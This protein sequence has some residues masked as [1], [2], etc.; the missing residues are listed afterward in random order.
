MKWAAGARRAVIGAVLAASVLSVGSPALG[1]KGVRY[2]ND[3][4]LRFDQIQLV[5]THNSYHLRPQPPFDFDA[6][7]LYDH[8]PT[9][10]QLDRGMRSFEFDAYNAPTTPVFHTLVIDAESR[11]ATLAKCLAPVAKWSRRNP[12]H[13]PMVVIVEPKDLPVAANPTIQGVIDS[14]VAKQQ[15]APWDTDGLDRLDAIVRKAFGSLLVTPDEVRAQYPTLRDAIIDR[16]WPTLGKMRGRVLALLLTEGI[17]R[18]VY[19]IGAS[20]LERRAMFVPSTPDMP[21]AAI[22][23]MEVPDPAAIA[24]RVRQ[25]FLVRTQADAFG[26][27]ARA[28]DRTR[29]RNA[30][31]GGAQVISTDYPVADP[32]VST[33]AVDLPGSAIARCNPID[34]PAWCRARDVER[35]T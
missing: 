8:A 10:A 28:N 11:C 6:E 3:D 32:T 27:E 30:I 34:T 25:H 19:P 13:V 7:T 5:G 31:K 26:V 17:S 9:T 23:Q 33:Y 24:E 22:I 18:D 21:S 14:E 12:T 29:A 35:D 1:A 16:G 20:S 15:L 2:P 4:R